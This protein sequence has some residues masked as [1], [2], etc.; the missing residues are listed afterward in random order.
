MVVPQCRLERS[1]HLY[2]RLG[3]DVDRQVAVFDYGPHRHLLLPTPARDG[4]ADVATVSMT[5]NLVWGDF[6][7]GGAPR[8]FSIF[9]YLSFLFD[10]GIRFFVPTQRIRVA[11]ARRSGHEWRVAPTCG[12]WLEHERHTW[13]NAAQPN[14]NEFAVSSVICSAEDERSL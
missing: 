9:L 5:M 2:H 14:C 1:G 10:L 12:V 8:A 7:Q 11:G 6:C 4:R 3:I 13:A